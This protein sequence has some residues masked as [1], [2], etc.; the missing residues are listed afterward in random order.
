VWHGINDLVRLGQFLASPLR[1][2][3]VDLRCDPDGRLAVRHD[4]FDAAGTPDDTPSA[5]GVVEAFRDAGKGLT[6]DVK[7]P[8]A[9]GAALRLIADVGLPPNAVCVNGRVDKLGERG[10]RHIGTSCPGAR[11]QCPVEFLGPMV[12]ALPAHARGV[13]TTVRSWGVDRFS[14]AW[15]HPQACDV[16]SQLE[17]WGLDVNLYAVTD[18]KCRWGRVTRGRQGSGRSPEGQAAAGVTAT[19]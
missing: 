6:L 9:L 11:I 19:S 4:D 5:R 13:L 17:T 12:V 14:M 18:R 8:E 3:E 10:L 15:T 7:E 16:L 2:G 1:W